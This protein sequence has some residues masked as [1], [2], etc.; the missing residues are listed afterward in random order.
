MRCVFSKDAPHLLVL[1][2][3]QSLQQKFLAWCGSR[4]CYIS[5]TE[6]VS[7]RYFH[8]IRDGRS[9]LQ[10][11]L[12][13][14]YYYIFAPSHVL[15]A[16]ACI[17]ESVCNFI[18]HKGR[19]SCAL[20]SVESPL[21]TCCGQAL[22]AWNFDR[23]CGART[24]FARIGQACVPCRHTLSGLIRFIR[25]TFLRYYLDHLKSLFNEIRGR[26]HRRV[27]T[28]IRYVDMSIGLVTQLRCPRYHR[29]HNVFGR[30]GFCFGLYFVRSLFFRSGPGV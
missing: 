7:G 6:L 3:H 5:D 30:S 15:W 25:A 27:N 12:Y 16:I 26:S 29:G 19:S 2:R 1:C 13:P 23:N 9:H 21:G 4:R 24:F 20:Y 14:Q 22:F 10:P 18:S 8:G 28:L 11:L 17:P